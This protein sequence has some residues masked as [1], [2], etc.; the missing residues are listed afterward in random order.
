MQFSEKMDI[1]PG[2]PF[3]SYSE[4][5]KDKVKEIFKKNYQKQFRRKSK[6]IIAKADSLGSL[7]ALFSFIEAGRNSCFEGGNRKH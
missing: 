2:M 6:G 7:E 4:K 3:L 5:E 1:L